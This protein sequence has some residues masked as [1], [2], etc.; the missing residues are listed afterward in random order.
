MASVLNHPAALTNGVAG[1]LERT[2]DENA[3]RTKRE[4]VRLTAGI[5]LVSSW[6]LASILVSESATESEAIVFLF[7]IGH[8]LM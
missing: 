4:S 7:C 2:R 5:E 6:A 3:D 1:I 8:D